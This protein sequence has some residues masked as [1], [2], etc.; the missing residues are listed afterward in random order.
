MRLTQE[1]FL[2]DV[3]S[4]RMAVELNRGLYRR[5]IFFFSSGKSTYNQWFEIITWPGALV[6]SGQIGSWVF[7]REQDMFEFFRG[8]QISSDYWSEKVEAADRDGIREFDADEFR[9]DALMQ[10]DNWD[11]D[12][13]KLAAARADLA[14]HLN[15]CD[16]EEE[17][18]R[19][20]AEWE[21]DGE[22]FDPVD[23]PS[24]MVYTRR[25]L[26]A[27]HA[28]RWAVEQYDALGAKP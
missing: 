25:F 1:E 27:C 7:R 23:M 4:H 12:E 20:W 17:L 5:L 2:A 26:W 28:I 10:L 14:E 21:F 18:R 15:P 24:G 16:T 6:M 19:A 9:S 8:K 13:S 11:L 3:A 22:A